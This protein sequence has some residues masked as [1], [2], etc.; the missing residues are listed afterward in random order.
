MYIIIITDCLDT[1]RS[2]TRSK[3]TERLKE[4]LSSSSASSSSSSSSS[5]S[6]IEQHKTP[7]V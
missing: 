4:C 5:S 2:E 3:H 7:Y 1:R 6:L